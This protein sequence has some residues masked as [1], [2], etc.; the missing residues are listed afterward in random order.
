LIE[1]FL[2]PGTS[3]S[4]DRFMTA[5]EILIVLAEKT[6]NRVRL[7]TISIGKALKTLGFLRTKNGTD[8]THGYFI[9]FKNS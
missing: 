8:R 9:R 7:S 2:E 4:Q 5:T 1:K 3:N 6:D